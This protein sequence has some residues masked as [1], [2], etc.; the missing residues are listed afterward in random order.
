MYKKELKVFVF[1]SEHID[2]MGEMQGT[3]IAE[4]LLEAERKAKEVLRGIDPPI[5]EKIEAD[6]VATLGSPTDVIEDIRYELDK[7]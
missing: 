6:I 7:I 5:D 2:G 3:V 4:S 1:K